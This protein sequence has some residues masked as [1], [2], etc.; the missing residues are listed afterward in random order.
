MTVELIGC[1]IITDGDVNVQG[2]NPNKKRILIARYAS[3]LAA[4]P[5]PP[6]APES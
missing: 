2:S 4:S 3:E 5:A 1:K 6:F